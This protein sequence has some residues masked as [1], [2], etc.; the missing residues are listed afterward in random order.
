QKRKK[1]LAILPVFFPFFLFI[2]SVS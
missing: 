2:F 1:R